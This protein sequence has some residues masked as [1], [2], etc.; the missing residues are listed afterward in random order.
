M[1]RLDFFLEK[2]KRACPFIR[3]VRVSN[4]KPVWNSLRQT[5]YLL[6]KV[7]LVNLIEDLTEIWI[8]SEINSP[9]KR[10]VSLSGI[11]FIHTS[12]ITNYTQNTYVYQHSR[13]ISTL[14]KKQ[15]QIS[16][17]LLHRSLQNYLLSLWL[18]YAWKRTKKY[19][20]YRNN[21]EISIKTCLGTLILF[22]KQRSN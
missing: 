6:S 18:Y 10:K 14:W 7:W 21:L 8:P 13:T 12:I 5:E 17:T 22:Y 3:E 1:C 16:Q 4:F 11:Y 15:K 2:N 9:L 20:I 19:T